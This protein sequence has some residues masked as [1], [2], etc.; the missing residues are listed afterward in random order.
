M[1]I[2]LGMTVLE[3]IKG[4]NNLTKL[5]IGGGAVLGATLEQR[6]QIREWEDKCF[7]ARLRGQTP[8]PPP[9]SI[10]PYVVGAV[11]GGILG[12]LSVK[13]TDYLSKL[14]KPQSG[15]SDLAIKSLAVAPLAVGLL[16]EGMHNRTQREKLR[17]ETLSELE[18]ERIRKEREK[19]QE[20]LRRESDI[21]KGRQQKERQI[22]NNEMRDKLQQYKLEKYKQK[23]RYKLAKKGIKMDFSYLIDDWVDIFIVNFSSILYDEFIAKD[24]SLLQQSAHVLKMIFN[25]HDDDELWNYDN[26]EIDKNID[27]IMIKSL[28][29]QVIV[30]NPTCNFGFRFDFKNKIFYCRLNKNDKEHEF[31]QCYYKKKEEQSIQDDCLSE[32]ADRWQEAVKHYPLARLGLSYNQTL[33]EIDKRFK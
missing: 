14:S 25:K 11:K 20:E 1:T 8:P 4:V 10:L 31:Y 3:K 28:P 7:E 22:L 9:K 24:R 18:R 26:L 32:L 30:Y 19:E 17:A 13:G 15:A 6:K 27:D 5:G 21:V 16:K 33:K 2:I 23:L 29:N 12:G